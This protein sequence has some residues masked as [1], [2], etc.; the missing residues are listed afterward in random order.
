MVVL[1]GLPRPF[2]TSVGAGAGFFAGLPRFLPA[3]SDLTVGGVT[4]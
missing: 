4:L 3:V 1:G 2:A